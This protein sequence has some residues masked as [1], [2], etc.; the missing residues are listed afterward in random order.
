MSK[1][2][3]SETALLIF[4]SNTESKIPKLKE[5]QRSFPLIFTQ[6]QVRFICLTKPKTLEFKKFPYKPTLIILS[7]ITFT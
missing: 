5:F 1:F 3:I 6:L 2:N 4:A 7:N